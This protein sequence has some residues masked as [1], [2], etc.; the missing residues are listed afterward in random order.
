MRLE[1]IIELESSI[2]EANGAVVETSHHLAPPARTALDLLLLVVIRSDIIVLGDRAFRGVL[3][4]EELELPPL[5]HHPDRSEF[6][7]PH[8]IG[9]STTTATTPFFFFR[10]LLVEP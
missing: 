2:E 3:L 9:I 7:I 10:N 4:L 5:I 1:S 6:G 8:K